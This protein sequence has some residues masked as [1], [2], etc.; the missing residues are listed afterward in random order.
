MVPHVCRVYFLSHI[1]KRAWFVFC[2]SYPST[3]FSPIYQCLSGELPRGSWRV[4]QSAPKSP[5]TVCLN[6]KG[7]EAYI[8]KPPSN[9]LINTSLFLEENDPVLNSSGLIHILIYYLL[10]GW[11]LSKMHYCFFIFLI[12]VPVIHIGPPSY[13]LKE[14]RQ[15]QADIKY[16]PLS[17][18]LLFRQMRYHMEKNTKHCQ[19][20]T[21]V[22]IF[23]SLLLPSCLHGNSHHWQYWL[24]G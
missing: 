22:Q 8:M 10:K 21:A 13:S 16:T 5:E 9:R 1:R 17:S 12:T 18:C 3:T 6:S 4:N 20:V 2:S 7:N 11:L 19:R 14:T 24:S 15:L 23:N